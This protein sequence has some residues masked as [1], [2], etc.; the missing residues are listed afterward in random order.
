MTTLYLVR[1][2]ETTEN[3][4]HI[5]QGHMPGHLTPLGIEQAQKLRDEL[6]GIH[7][8]AL[9]SSDL[10]RCLDTAAILNQ[11]RMLPLQTTDLMRE[12]DWGSFTGKYIPDIQGV[13]F[14]DDIESVEAMLRRG[15]AFL[16]Y[17]LDRFPNQCVLAVGHGLMNR[18]IQAVYHGKAMREIERMGNATYRILL[19]EDEDD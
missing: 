2:G 19:L 9:L 12:R 6:A 16:K 1:H 3:V 4:A 11:E 10:Q 17:V 7:F 13:P 14:P 5:L 15:A 8:D 18:A